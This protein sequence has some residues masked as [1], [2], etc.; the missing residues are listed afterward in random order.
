MGF[1]DFFIKPD[2]NTNNNTQEVDNT[3]ASANRVQIVQQQPIVN[4]IPSTGSVQI[5]NE[6]STTT[7]DNTIVDNIQKVMISNSTKNNEPDYLTVKQ[8]AS[9]LI[10]MSLPIAQAF[11]GGFRTIKKSHP[12]FTKELLLKSID[13]YI[14]I[15][16]KERANGKEQCAQ[17]YKEKV[18]DKENSIKEL[19]K[20]KADLKQQLLSIQNEINNTDNTISTLKETIAQDSSEIKKK[21]QIF[22]NS[23]DY[24][25]D[26]LNKDK[27]IINIINI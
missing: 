2:E 22:N 14:S 19:E 9:A 10:E 1:K 6:L 27:S 20:T 12:E 21:E 11:E 26:S 17:L 18:G 8:N 13:N 3:S 15:V 23:V 16:E 4:Q 24:V 5:S 25:L 7:I